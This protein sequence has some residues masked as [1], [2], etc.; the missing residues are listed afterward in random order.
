MLPRRLRDAHQ[1]LLALFLAA[2]TQL[3]STRACPQRRCRLCFCP[4][5]SASSLQPWQFWRSLMLAG[6]YIGST[7]PSSLCNTTVPLV[8]SRSRPFQL[9]FYRISNLPRAENECRGATEQ[10]HRRVFERQRLTRDL[11][12]DSAEVVGT[13]HAWKSYLVLSDLRL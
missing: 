4:S 8:L 6:A 12:V 13:I 2:R 1:I 11:G 10:C 5:S 7:A 9:C 3:K